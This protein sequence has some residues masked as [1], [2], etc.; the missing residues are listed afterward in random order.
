MHLLLRSNL[1]LLALAVAAGGACGGN[2]IVDGSGGSTT[3]SSSSSSSTTTTGLASSSTSS[4]GFSSTSSTGSST[5][6]SG[7]G[8]TDISDLGILGAQVIWP[9]EVN[10][11]MQN[12]GNQKATQTCLEAATGLSFACTLCLAQDLMCAEAQCLNICLSD[13]NAPACYQC[14]QMA[15]GAAFVGCSGLSRQTGSTSCAAQY[16]NGPTQTPWAHGLPAA[17]FTTTTGYAAYQKYDSCACTACPVCQMDY[18]GGAL[19][20]NPNCDNCIQANCGGGVISFC[21]AN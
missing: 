3:K 2:V 4:T 8:C 16:G 14:R 6:S 19:T 21:Q 15:C 1:F 18:C 11:A 7:G 5:S 13:P 12:A 9:T 10:C 20:A 17:D